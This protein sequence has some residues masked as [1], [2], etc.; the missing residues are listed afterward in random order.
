METGILFDFLQEI[1]QQEQCLHL[2]NNV[3]C[4][5]PTQDNLSWAYRSEV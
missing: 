2:Q 3:Q 5:G 1:N 4:W